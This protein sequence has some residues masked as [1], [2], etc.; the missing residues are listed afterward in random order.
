M[1]RANVIAGALISG[2]LLFVAVKGDLP[3]YQAIF[4]G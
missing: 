3:K 1:G 4:T 2:F